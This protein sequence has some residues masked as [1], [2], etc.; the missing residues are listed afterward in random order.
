MYEMNLPVAYCHSK[1]V[2]LCLLLTSFNSWLGELEDNLK[3]PRSFLFL[4]FEGG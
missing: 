4:A 2:R 1:L 3:A